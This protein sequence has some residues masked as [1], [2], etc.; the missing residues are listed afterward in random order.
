MAEVR[1]VALG[2]SFTEGVG[3]E[4]DGAPR[5]WADLVA[6]GLA[7]AHGEI[8]YANLAVRGRLLEPIA[9][10]QVAAALALDPAPTL[11]TL[12]GGGNDMLRP[13]LDVHRLVKLTTAAVRQCLQAGVEVVLLAGPDPSAR[14]PFPRMIHTRGSVLTAR[15]RE[16][17]DAEGLTFANV[18]ADQEI[19]RAP[20]W[21]PD[22]LHLNALGHRR[23][24]DLVLAAMGHPQPERALPPQPA[25]AGRAHRAREDA[26]YYRAHVLPWVGR[27]VR[28]TS[29]G[30]GR[31]PKL[32]A[33]VHLT[34]DP[35]S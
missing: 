35:A 29:S 7:A 6:Q 34:A 19:R 33:W 5:G 25:E 14:L 28:R 1:F 20:Y 17:A 12:N 2:D 26:R 11:L 31:A 10:E 30:D 22:R 4:V 3:D 18:F 16:L 27:R 13:G 21:G 24:A 15:I 8:S 9:T 23:A 32:P